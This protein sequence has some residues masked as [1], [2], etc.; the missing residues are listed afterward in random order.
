[1][2]DG[3]SVPLDIVK[4]IMQHLWLSPLSIRDR[5]KVIKSSHLVSKRWAALFCEIESRDVFI[6]SPSH[7]KTFVS[8]LLG[9]TYF[10]NSYAHGLLCRSITFQHA[11]ESILPSPSMHRG[12]PMIYDINTVLYHISHSTSP[13]QLPHLRRISVELE[14]Y[15]MESFFVPNTFRFFPLQVTDLELVFRYSADTSPSLLHAIRV[16]PTGRRYPAPVRGS[17]PNISRLRLMGS[18]GD[19]LRVMG[20]ACSN[21]RWSGI[22][23]DQVCTDLS[24]ASSLHSGPA[25]ELA[26]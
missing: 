17:L 7:A 21:L 1:M 15:L 2:T 13:F 3:I 19:V 16:A 5:A 14:N 18:S 12:L 9:K 22:E 23:Q 8:L 6:I 4:D 25:H 11:R 20:E 26:Q 24:G 10:L